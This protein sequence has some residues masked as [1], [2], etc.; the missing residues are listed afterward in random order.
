VF[1]LTND[2]H[3]TTID[4]GNHDSITL[5]NVQLASLHAN[6]FIIG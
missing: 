6:N 3:D 4:L 5:S 2:G 1:S